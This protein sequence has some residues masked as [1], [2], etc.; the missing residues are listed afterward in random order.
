M[1]N[2]S[3]IY[4]DFKIKL[5]TKI[6][7]MIFEENEKQKFNEKIDTLDAFHYLSTICGEIMADFIKKLFLKIKIC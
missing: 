1:S 4:Q 5:L 6:G 7:S 2:G 3:R